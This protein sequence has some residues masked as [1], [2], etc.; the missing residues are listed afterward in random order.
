MFKFLQKVKIAYVALSIVLLAVGICLII[1]PSFFA[2][3]IC[4]IIGSVSLIAGVV[5]LVVFFA[6]DISRLTIGYSLVTGILLSIFGLVLLL[7]T[8]SSVMFFSTLFG[9]FIIID[10]VIKLQ[11]SFELR[12]IGVSRWWINLL[13]SVASAVLGVLL[14][15][16][17]FSAVN[18]LLIF[19]GLSLVFDALENIWTIIFISYTSKK[20]KKMEEDSITIITG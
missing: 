16:N 1:W 8:D 11:A 7:K 5:S 4:Y 14:V 15:V 12:V 20:Y 19:V 3:I 10:S 13:L 2:T 6:R 18:V 17:P 9:V